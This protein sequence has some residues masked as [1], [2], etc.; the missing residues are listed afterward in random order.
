MHSFGFGMVMGKRNDDDYQFKAGEEQQFQ[1]I[2]VLCLVNPSIDP[3][4]L[5]TLSLFMQIIY[6]RTSSVKC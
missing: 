4:V 3:N 1:H 2:K 6:V 5:P